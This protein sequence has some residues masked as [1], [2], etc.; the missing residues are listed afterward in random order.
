MQRGAWPCLRYRRIEYDLG[1]DR[2]EVDPTVAERD[3]LNAPTDA[4]TRFLQAAWA[5]AR[6]EGL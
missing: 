4:L 3:G 2:S 6:E 5:G 1:V